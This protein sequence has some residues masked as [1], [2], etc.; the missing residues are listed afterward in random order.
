MWKVKFLLGWPH[1]SPTGVRSQAEGRFT[2]GHGHPN[3]SPKN[4]WSCIEQEQVCVVGPQSG[5]NVTSSFL[6]LFAKE[7]VLDGDVY[8]KADTP[9]KIRLHKQSL[10]QVCS[11]AG[12]LWAVEELHGFHKIVAVLLFPNPLQERAN[13]PAL[14]YF[15]FRRQR[16]ALAVRANEGPWSLCERRGVAP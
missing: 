4:L 6:R 14:K 10:G 1:P 7:L 2:A 13:T 16:V 12:P 3:G 11:S 9:E 5:A 8:A 15:F